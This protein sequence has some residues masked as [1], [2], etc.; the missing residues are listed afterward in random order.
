[1]SSIK[2][3]LPLILFA[4]MLAA[5]DSATPA[6]APKPTEALK[7]PVVEPCCAIPATTEAPKPVASTNPAPTTAASSSFTVK[8]LSFK[9]DDGSGKPGKE[10]SAF[11]TADKV[12]HFE[13]GLDRLATNTKIKMDFFAVN[14]SR[15]KN[16]NLGAVEGNVLIGNNLTFKVPITGKMRVGQYRGDLYVGDKL[17]KEIEFVV[18]PEKPGD[19]VVTEAKLFTDDGKGMAGNEVKVFKPSDLKQH[20]EFATT[21]ALTKPAKV[22]WKFSAI[23]TNGTL[24]AIKDIGGEFWLEDTT[25]T[26]FLSNT[27]DFPVGKYQVEL[28]VNDKSVKK[29]EYEVK[30]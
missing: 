27:K 25:L 20:F 9:R 18:E 4:A 26:S 10:V 7:P 23:E 8:N 3:A 22:K 28:F 13:I 15:T 21:G 24:I 1:M 30:G 14:T 5:C 16:E 12:W 19:I 2:F 6:A 17:V 29:L 11:N